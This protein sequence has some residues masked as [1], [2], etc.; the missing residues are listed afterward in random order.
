MIRYLFY[1]IGDLTYQSP[2][3][4][5]TAVGELNELQLTLI[6]GSQKTFISQ[7]QLVHAPNHNFTTVSV[8]ELLV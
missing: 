7:L 3:V 1:T 8:L 2:L 4:H 6:P 5:K